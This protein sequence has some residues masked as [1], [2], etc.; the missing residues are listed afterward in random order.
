MQ[1]RD[2]QAGSSACGTHPWELLNA[3]RNCQQPRSRS[4]AM[5]IISS[6][7]CLRLRRPPARLNVAVMTPICIHFS[8]LQETCGA[9]QLPKLRSN[10]FAKRRPILGTW[11]SLRGTGSHRQQKPMGHHRPVCN[12]SQSVGWILLTIMLLLGSPSH[13]SKFW[14]PSS[15][16]HARLLILSRKCESP[17]VRMSHVSLTSCKPRRALRLGQ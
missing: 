1:A 17:S 13:S 10:T 11:Q 15:F 9:L 14:R 4:L 6:R 3:V 7:H 2:P 8:H 12:D 5:P 16:S